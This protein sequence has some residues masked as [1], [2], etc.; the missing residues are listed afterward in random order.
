MFRHPKVLQH[1]L[2][3]NLMKVRTPD[4]FLSALQLGLLPTSAEQASF[5]RARGRQQATPIINTAGTKCPDEP[6]P[7]LL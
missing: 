3:R 1:L 7:V 6:F 5:R 4:N 2:C